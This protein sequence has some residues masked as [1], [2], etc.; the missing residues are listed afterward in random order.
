MTPTGTKIDHVIYDGARRR[1]S[2]DVLVMAGNGPAARIRAS[3]PG[4]PKWTHRQI[5]RALI[6]SARTHPRKQEVQNA[7]S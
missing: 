2:G 7:C 4:H 6:E 3:A 5:T 1:F